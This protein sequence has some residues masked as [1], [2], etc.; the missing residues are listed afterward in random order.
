MPLVMVLDKHPGH[1]ATVVKDYVNQF[2]HVTLVNTPTQSPDLNPIEHLWDWLA[3]QRIKN[4]FFETTT[5]LKQAVRRF[6]CYIAGVKE[7]VI[8]WLG[9]LQELYTAGAEI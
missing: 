9:N 8:S 3:E 7:H 1:T 6:F 5:A 2:D 4:A